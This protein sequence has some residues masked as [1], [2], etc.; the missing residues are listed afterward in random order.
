M[1]YKNYDDVVRQ[2]KDIG[3]LVELPLRIAT[4]KKSVRCRVA[5]DGHEKLGW[6]R[7]YEWL[8]D[9]GDLM[10]TGSFGIYHGDDPGTF[11]VDLT[12]TCSACGCEMALTEKKCPACGSTEIKRRELSDEEKAAQKARYAEAKKREAA[13]RLAEIERAAQWAAAVWKK[14]RDLQPG[15]HDYLVRK[16]LVGTG[17]A[18][19]FE[20]NDG[21]DLAGAEKHDY[22]YL[23][24]FRGALVIPMRNGT[25]KIF[26]LQFILDRKL[27]HDRIRRTERDKE[28]WPAGLSKDGHFHL[29]G[30]SPAGVCLVAEGF[31]TALSL[32]M[33][34]GKPVVVAFDAGNLPK[35]AAAL[36]KTYRKTK[37]LICADDDWL[38]KCAEVECKK[39]TPVADTNCAHCGKPHRKSNAG[40]QRAQEAAGDDGA[41][42]YPRFR[43]RWPS[44]PFR[45][46]IL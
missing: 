41:W 16:K 44:A 27:H 21:L 1:S 19:I 32:H 24:S 18:R 25:G 22:T 31:A 10:L 39:Y 14:C 20:G 2:L 6:Y 11:K 7:L 23:G 15:E 40:R 45:K 4:G 33:A 38:Q 12:K 43:R 28:Y 30:S 5:G 3:L 17:G 34:S 13:E 36:R 35:V 26:G 8:M 9:S 46:P 42:L 29:I 37:L